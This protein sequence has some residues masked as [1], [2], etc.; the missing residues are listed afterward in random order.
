MKTNTPIKKLSQYDKEDTKNDL[1]NMKLTN[2]K[3]KDNL[4]INPLN[5]SNPIGFFNKQQYKLDKNYISKNHIKS[6]NLGKSTQIKNDHFNNSSS[7][8][9]NN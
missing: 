4:M 9:S 6:E 8:L 1:F 2:K 5:M 7:V 3:E